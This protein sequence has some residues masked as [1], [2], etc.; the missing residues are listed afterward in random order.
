MSLVE[1]SVGQ[2]LSAAVDAQR[3]GADLI[4]LRLDCIEGVTGEGIDFLFRGLEPLGVPNVATV[5]PDSLFGRYKGGDSA[6]ARLLAIAA[7]HADYVDLNKEMAPG[8][9]GE[10]MKAV[11]EGGARPIISWHSDRMLGIEEMRRFL[12][13]V[14]AGACAT[15][16]IVMPASRFEDNLAA[17][18]A[19]S[20][21]AGHSRIVF[22]CGWEGRISRI[23]SPFFGSE[24][25]YASLAE[26]KE[27]APG[28]VDIKTM[29]RVQE[30]FS[31]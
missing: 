27:A 15:F 4:E 1:G 7:S 20:S 14:E 11:A 3:N 25:A 31:Q 21:L 17:L 2:M 13:S 12:S 28:Q 9:F 6:R 29:R 30:V 10:C 18:G 22:C 8:E 24:W 26:G 19:C 16:K 23:L 5:M